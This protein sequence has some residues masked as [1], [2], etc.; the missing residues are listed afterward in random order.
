M[1]RL[2]G[3]GLAI[4]IVTVIWFWPPGTWFVPDCQLDGKFSDWRGRANLADEQENKASANDWR[5]LYWTTNPNEQNLY[6]MIERFASPNAREGMTA[7]LFFDINANGSYTNKI[8]R[9]AEI[10]Y[11][12]NQEHAGEVKVELFTVQGDLIGTYGGSWGEG[13][14]DGGRRCEFA[15]PMNKLQVYPA[16]SIRF[17]LTSIG[18]RADRL[19]DSQDNQWSPFPVTVKSKY[20]IVIA[21]MVWLAV[22]LFLYRH[23]N[24]VFYYVWGAIGLSCLMILLFQGSWVEYH[25]EHQT[26]MLLHNTLKNFDIVTYVFDKSRGRCWF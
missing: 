13:Y 20:T 6:F 23:R 19:P 25:L 16:Q 26:S 2:L 10:S 21:S 3:L 4:L 14:L 11:R 18:E 1:K 22:T 15:L 17:Y 5:Y 9:Y 7:R 24:W 8:D 12:P